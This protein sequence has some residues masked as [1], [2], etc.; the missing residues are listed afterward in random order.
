MVKLIFIRAVIFLNNIWKMYLIETLKELKVYKHTFIHSRFLPILACHLIRS[1]YISVASS[2]SR[3][4][5]MC[6]RDR[7]LNLILFLLYTYLLILVH[8]FKVRIMTCYLKY[9][10][11]LFCQPY[12]V[13]IFVAQHDQIISVLWPNIFNIF[14]FFL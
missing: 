8:V 10:I 4:P 3:P 7:M 2:T 13:Y 5:H 11:Y 12:F 9:L 6:T 1:L 14:H